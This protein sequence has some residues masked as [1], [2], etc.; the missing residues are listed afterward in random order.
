MITASVS[1]LAK[2]NGATGKII[3]PGDI[4]L[5]LDTGLLELGACQI[6]LNELYRIKVNYDPI[7]G[8]DY[9]GMLILSTVH[10]SLDVGEYSIAH[11]VTFDEQS[12]SEVRQLINKFTDTGHRISTGR[13]S[14]EIVEYALP[15]EAF[16]TY[17]SAA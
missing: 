5:H 17:L 3:G 8:D 11:R 2:A 6:Q 12:T 15:H 10:N 14:V 16:A 1:D 9:G 13:D 7:D 4:R